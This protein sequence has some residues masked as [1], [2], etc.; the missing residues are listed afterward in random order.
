MVAMDKM[1]EEVQTGI[2]SKWKRRVN[3]LLYVMADKSDD[4]L[5]ILPLTDQ[6]KA[7]YAEVTETS[8]EHFVGKHNVI[9]EHTKF[10]SRQ[11]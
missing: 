11:Q 4:I 8:G 3:S 5:R 10:N 7:A 9:Y 6:Q 1:F 2:R